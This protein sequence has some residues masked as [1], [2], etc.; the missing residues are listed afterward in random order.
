MKQKQPKYQFKSKQKYKKKQ[1][2]LFVLLAVCLISISIVFAR[3]VTDKENPF[4]IRSKEFYFYSDKLKEN[5]ATYQIENWSGADD[6]TITINMNSSKNNLK[7]VNYDIGY[8]VNFTCSDNVICQLSKTEGIIY[9][10][11]NQDFFNLTI[12]PNTYLKTGDKV[13]VE[14]EATSTTEF[15]KTLKGKFVLIV[16]QENLSFQ[17]S[18][19]PNNPYMQLRI[20]N[21]LTYYVVD[22]PF[23]GYVE[24]Q[25]IDS[26]TYLSLNEADRKKCHSSIVNIK[27]NPKDILMDMTNEN[28]QN[29]VETKKTTINGYSYINEVT[30][31]IDA[32]SSCDL[33]FYKVDV[34]KDYTY[35]NNGNNPIV[36]ITS[37]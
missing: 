27:F 31:R 1:L 4:L 34:S 28:F 25:R 13:T 10:S 14:I 19:S 21:T 7:S 8:K 17:I 3:Y 36:T 15:H 32:V 26:D 2:I 37:K 11:T 35:P 29:A 30:I 16:G 23:N 20:T 24:G 33:R 18:D 5:T 6:Y 22:Q 12:T 9:A